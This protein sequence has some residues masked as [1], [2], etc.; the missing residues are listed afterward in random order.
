MSY[1]EYLQSKLETFVPCGRECRPEDVHPRLFDF[2]KTLVC[3][4]AKMGRAA[5]FAGCGLGKT[6]IQ[7]EWA[8]ITAG[9]DG[10][11]LIYAPLT[12]A[13]QTIDEAK[14]LGLEVRYVS[15]A[16]DI[17]GP[18]M[19][20]SN[21]ERAH[22]FSEL[23]VS[24]IVL[25]ESGILK[26][27][28]GS[29]R[30]LLVGQYSKTPFRLCCTATPA[31]NDITE[32]AN[33]S[34]FLGVKSR[35]ELLSTYFVHDQDG[36]R[37]KGHATEEF[38]RWM[39][40]WAVYL[41]TPEDIGFD[42]SR[43]VLP[44]LNL[45]DHIVNAE[46]VPEGHLFP[47]E[48]TKGIVGRSELR[49]L[50]MEDRVDR[51]VE[52]VNSND[53]QWLVWV[54][55]NDES[56][57]IQKALPNAVTV[58]GSDSVEDR[59]TALRAF[60][61]GSARVLIS[62]PKVSGFGINFQHCSQMVFCG[63]NDSWEQY[64]QA[65]RRCWRF[66]QDK[67][68]DVHIVSSNSEQAIVANVKGKE[69][70]AKI[71]G[72][73]IIKNIGDL[74]KKAIRQ[75]S[76]RGI[77]EGTRDVAHGKDWTMWNGD[78]VEVL[79]DHVADN[80][81]DLSVYSPPFATLYTYSDSIRD[82]GNCKDHEEFFEGYKYVCEQMLRV[83]KPGRITCV[84]V[85]QLT[86]RKYVDGFIGLC[87][88]RGLVIQEYKRA[89][90]QHFGEFAI[91]KCPQALKDG[92]PVLTPSGWTAIE[93]LRV[94]DTVYGQ[95]GKPTKVLGVWPQGKRESYRVTFY[96][97]TFVDCDADHLWNVRTGNNDYLTRK[98]T[99]LI[100]L[101]SDLEIP[102]VG[103]VEFQEKEL[104]IDPYTL[105]VL[106]G[107]GSM[108]QRATVSV[109]TD[110]SI[111]NDCKVPAGHQWR[112]LPGTEKAEGRV[113][114]FNVICDE[115]HKNDVL[116]AT[117]E[118]G[119]QGCRSWEKFIPEQYLF[120][121]IEQRRELLR[122]LMDTDGK[123]SKRGRKEYHTTSS[124]LADDVKH[125]VD[126]L[127]GRAMVYRQ[128][129]GKYEWNGEERQ[130][131]DLYVV[132]ISLWGSWNPFKLER[133]AE[134]FKCNSRRRRMTIKSIE[135]TG[136]MSDHTCITVAAPD[137]L[138]V[139]K[140]F[141][142]TH[143]SQAIR[144]KAHSLMFVTKNKDR[145]KIRPALADF[146][147]LFKKPGENEVPIRSD[148]VSNED[149]IQWAH[150][151]WTGIRESDTL[152]TRAAKTEKDERHICPLQLQVIERCV[153]LWSNPGELVLSPFAGIGSEGYESIKAGRKFVGIELKREYWQQAQ[154]NIEAAVYQSDQE[155]SLFDDLEEVS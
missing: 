90:W 120:S 62:K 127:G 87:D 92:T 138:F 109:C 80:S 29:T 153:K 113:A 30:N 79:R 143:N 112:F 155:L 60:K 77:E 85:Q 146:I 83:T 12:V 82:L 99:D 5:V 67:P 37:L 150:P 38:Y 65:I 94:G 34:E 33:H 132:A 114:S 111:V 39:A 19:Y 78:C 52:L 96:D 17:D 6:N 18:G 21:Y 101:K 73:Q 28:A 93:S 154:K 134:R 40:S 3:W 103:E 76:E 25:D 2:Q 46:I 140:N 54:G 97:G 72:D 55:L 7:L 13:E 81:V 63:L 15:D 53:G 51:V 105:G 86:T 9:P 145:S 1:T 23:S 27:F 116:E 57:L 100:G 119:L 70:Q 130:G 4:A 84:H 131:R 8:R 10:T 91:Q 135:R 106:I 32:I 126:S 24:S 75:Q 61:S 133:K 64:Y 56:T 68:V 118:L 95:D 22:K 117:R 50:T 136:E 115:W 20:I 104:L 124:R 49:K 35:V 151:I 66:G 107:D 139:T 42:G 152:N 122:G 58:E 11:A 71:M 69:E 123:I 16:G 31:P 44:P 88:F 48:V 147:L 98:T 148:E 89:G 144:T 41:R 142:V 36:W 110:L 14:L 149:W 137:G 125:L 74:S 141:I 59:L 108:S 121:S 129:G 26:N 43:Y 102:M 128:D 47:V 45:H